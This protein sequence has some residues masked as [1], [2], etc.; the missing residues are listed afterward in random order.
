VHIVGPSRHLA[1]LVRVSSP[2]ATP[3]LY[4]RSASNVEATLQAAGKQAA[5]TPPWN[6]APRAPLGPSDV[7]LGQCHIR[8][9]FDVAVHAETHLES[10]DA[11]LRDCDGF[12]EVVP[13]K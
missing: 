10:G 4:A 3:I 12:P 13:S 6:V 1:P 2:R 11:L 9:S 8:R 7:L 5:V